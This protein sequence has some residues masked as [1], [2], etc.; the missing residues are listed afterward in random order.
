[1]RRTVRTLSVAVLA[2][3]AF[4]ATGTAAAAAGPVAGISPG[5]VRPGA[6][7]TVPV[8]CGTAAD[9]RDGAQAPAQVA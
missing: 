6:V 3:A 4:G 1:M 7:V 8:A 2:G 5:S 9:G